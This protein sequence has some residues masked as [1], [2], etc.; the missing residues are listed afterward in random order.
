MLSTTHWLSAFA[1]GLLLELCLGEPKRLHPLV[2]F[3]WLAAKLERCFNLAGR[4]QVSNS[5]PSPQKTV[6]PECFYRG[7]RTTAGFPP[8]WE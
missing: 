1:L 3:G 2:G 5:P 8:S 6:I 7:S 4:L